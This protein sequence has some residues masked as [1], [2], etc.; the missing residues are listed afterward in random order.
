MLPLVLVAISLAPVVAIIWFIYT[1]DKYEKEPTRLLILAFVYGLISVIPALAGSYLGSQTGIN[2]NAGLFDA[3]IFAFVIVALA[4]ELGKFLLLRYGLFNH[5]SF[6][7]PFDGIV[8]SVMIGMGFAAL[9]NVLYA[10]DGGLQVAILRMFTAVPGHASFGVIMGYYVGLAKFEPQKRNQ[11]LLTGLF[12]A[13]IA[14]GTYD[15]FLMQNSIPGIGFGA[16]VALGV[17]I[18]Y[19]IIAIKM[20]QHVSPFKN[21]SETANTNQSQSDTYTVNNTQNLNTAY[22]PAE[23]DVIAQITIK[24]YVEENN[25]LPADSNQEDEEQTE[26]INK[27]PRKPPIIP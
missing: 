1:R 14:H 17:C 2:P 19:C 9:E 22:S 10:L 20:H 8:Y 5:K 7:E 6:D 13:T 11:H 3:F 4:E 15:F 27:S 21:M 24:P 23:L 18:R 25:E 12:G 26:D 16:F